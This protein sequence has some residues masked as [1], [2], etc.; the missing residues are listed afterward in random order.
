[1]V[2][3]V[4]TA[5]PRLRLR[6]RARYR[7]RYRMED[8]DPPPTRSEGRDG[9]AC[10]SGAHPIRAGR[11]QAPSKSNRSTRSLHL[12]RCLAPTW[13]SECEGGNRGERGWEM[14]ASG[15]VPGPGAR[16]DTYD[17]LSHV[18]LCHDMTRVPKVSALAPAKRSSMVGGSTSEG[19]RREGR[20][21]WPDGSRMRPRWPSIAGRSRSP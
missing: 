6:A 3:K 4:Y 14:G 10:C 11:C 7:C 9:R 19:L 13:R 2:L 8:E 15:P 17:R 16:A 18:D 21:G 1:M 12:R 20:E 5:Q